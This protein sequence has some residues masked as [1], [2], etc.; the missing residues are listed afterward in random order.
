MGVMVWAAHA[1]FSRGWDVPDR[2]QTSRPVPRVPDI[3]PVTSRIKMEL[4]TPEI[5]L[6][7]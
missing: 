5:F 3:I 7:I 2:G 6:S 1:W 4:Y